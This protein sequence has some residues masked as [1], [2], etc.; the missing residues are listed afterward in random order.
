MQ[1]F[2][3]IIWTLF[4]MGHPNVTV[5][6][7][8]KLHLGNNSRKKKPLRITHFRITGGKSKCPIVGELLSKLF[9]R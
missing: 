8:G 6:S 3:K 9:S 2:R 5:I 1:T 7:L 4:V